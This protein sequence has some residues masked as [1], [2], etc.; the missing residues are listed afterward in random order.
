VFVAYIM[1]ESAEKQIWAREQIQEWRKA[2]KS[3]AIIYTMG[4]VSSEKLNDK[5]REGSITRASATAQQLY[6]FVLTFLAVVIGAIVPVVIAVNLETPDGLCPNKAT[7]AEKFIG[8]ILCLFFVVLTINM[9]LNK[10]RGMGF[11]KLFCSKE[12]ELL[13]VY[14]F[15]LDLGILSNLISMTAAGVCQY[16]LFLTNVNKSYVTQLLQSLAM[17]FVLTTDQK[18]M[19]GSLSAFTVQR[20][21]IL[22]QH[23]KH[24]AAEEG[25]E[26]NAIPINHDILKKVNLMY[27]AEIVFLGFVSVIG[28]IWSITVAAC[29]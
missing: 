27:T 7:G 20:L 28:L 9:C 4:F 24:E 14:R 12:V 19:T 26:D 17:Q 6:L 1:S 21:E 16:I 18:L 13:G 2:A 10:L 15:F 29:Q 22:M 23:D 5:K 25:T 8:F 3:N 11:L